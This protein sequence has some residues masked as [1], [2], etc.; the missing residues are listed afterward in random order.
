MVADTSMS[1]FKDIGELGQGRIRK[2]R[3]W[4]PELDGV[5]I[6][7]RL[8]KEGYYVGYCDWKLNRIRLSPSALSCNH[9]IAH[10]LTH[11]ASYFCGGIPKG[12]KACDLWTLARSPILN[13]V[14]PPYLDLPDMIRAEWDRNTAGLLSDL[15]RT[16]IKQRELGMRQYIKWFEESVKIANLFR[17]E[18]EVVGMSV[19]SLQTAGGEGGRGDLMQGDLIKISNKILEDLRDK[20]LNRGEVSIICEIVKSMARTIPKQRRPSEMKQQRQET[21]ECDV[22][23]AEGPD[24]MEYV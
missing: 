4:F 10:E 22:Q 20:G 24:L 2:V 5:P 6:D 18:C 11:M 3:E 7:F 16:S 12:E 17:T 9:V 14:S 21:L 13:E 8:M 1:T 23:Q 19:P 15:A